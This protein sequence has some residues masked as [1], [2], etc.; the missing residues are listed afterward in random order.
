MNTYTHSAT[1]REFKWRDV[2]ISSKTMKIK[3]IDQNFN[4]FFFVLCEFSLT[5]GNKRNTL[6]CGD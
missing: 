4:Q 3:H 2:K 1:K 6:L 5:C